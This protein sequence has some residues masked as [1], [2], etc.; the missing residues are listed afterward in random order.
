MTIVYDPRGLTWDNY[1]RYMQ[2]LF[3]AN[4]LGTMPEEKW[5]TWAAGVNGIGYFVQSGV[6][7]PRSFQNWQDWAMALVGIMTVEDK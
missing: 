6:P 5:Q 1:C 7:D 2:E 3:A 4:D